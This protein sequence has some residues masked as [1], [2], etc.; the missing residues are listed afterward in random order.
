MGGVKTQHR[1]IVMKLIA[2][3]K[4]R[5]KD[6]VIKLMDIHSVVKSRKKVSLNK[7]LPLI[8]YQQGWLRVTRALMFLWVISKG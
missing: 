3:M 4:T 6:M 8:M 5:R 2:E 7:A 1:D